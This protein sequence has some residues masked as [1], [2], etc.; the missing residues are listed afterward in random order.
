[1]Q[2]R[3][4]H[5]L[6]RPVHTDVTRVMTTKNAAPE[7]EEERELDVEPE[8][9]YERFEEHEREHRDEDERTYGE[10]YEEDVEG[11]FVPEDPDEYE[12]G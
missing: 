3:P 12:K 7:P 11:D 6:T 5:R 1:M 9:E 8:Q 4:I 2:T 10:S